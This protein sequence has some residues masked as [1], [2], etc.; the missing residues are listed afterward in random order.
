MAADL[1]TDPNFRL[2]SFERLVERLHLDGTNASVKP[3]TARKR[4]NL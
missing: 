4:E 2:T 1:A 3:E